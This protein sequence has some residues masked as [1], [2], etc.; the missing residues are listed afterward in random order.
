MIFI[1]FPGIGKSTICNK[2]PDAIDLES[3]ICRYNNG[4]RPDNW[5][6]IYCK[7]AIY[8]SEQGF[9][10]FV[11]SHYKVQQILVEKAKTDS[12]IRI[13]GIAP[14]INLYEDWCE[15]LRKRY[16]DSGLSKDKRAYEHCK[17]WFEDSIKNMIY[18]I[19]NIYL[20]PSVEYD[21]EYIVNNIESLVKTYQHPVA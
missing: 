14:N 7:Y 3:S 20:I 13:Y 12:N 8:L 21:L 9:K 18:T 15:K 10:I 16:E 1:G 5:E 17:V 11:S 2:L 19:P 4:I 6:E